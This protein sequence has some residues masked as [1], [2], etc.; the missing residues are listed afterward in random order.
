MGY[1]AWKIDLAKAYDK[2][3]WGFIKQVLEE[4]GTEGKLNSLIMSCITNV[5]YKVAL[6]GEMS[7][8]FLPKCGIRQGDPLSPY[9]FV[10]CM[11]KLSHIIKQQIPEGAWKSVKISIAGPEISHLFFADDLI[12]FGQASVQQAKIMRECLDT[13][14]DL[15]WQQVCFPKSRIHCSKNV[16]HSIARV[17]ANVCGSPVSKNLGNYLGVPLIHGRI[18]KDTYKE[19]IEKTQNKLANW[20]SASLS[21]AGRCTLIKAVTS[22]LPIYAIY[23][24]YAMQSI[25]LPS[26]TCSTLDQIN[27]NFLWGNTSD[28]KKIHLVNWDTV[29]IPK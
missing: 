9:V 3:Q 5:Q 23:A 10:L 15:S 1:M 14:C 2:L 11:E 12:L 29:C 18:T 21:F 7:E 4:I 28:K 19:I 24:I 17:L 26:E 22:A 16:S 6:N 27:R 13:F 25:K 8:T 20:K